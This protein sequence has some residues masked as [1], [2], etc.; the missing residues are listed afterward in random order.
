MVQLQAGAGELIHQGHRTGGTGEEVHALRQ[1]AQLISGVCFRHLQMVQATGGQPL[2]AGPAQVRHIEVGMQTEAEGH[3]LATGL[4]LVVDGGDD[5]Q[6]TAQGADGHAHLKVEG[7]GRQR[8]RAG[9]QRELNAALVVKQGDAPGQV[10]REPVLLEGDIATGQRQT[11]AG[12]VA[13]DGE[14]HGDAT[15]NALAGIREAL[16]VEIENLALV[17]APLRHQATTLGHHP[18]AIAT[19]GVHKLPVGIGR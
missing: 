2:E 7:V 5:L 6:G 12:Q 18:Q 3:R 16:L 17:A 8:L 1:A 14:Q 15:A 13:A 9:L 11:V 4:G 19:G 10:A